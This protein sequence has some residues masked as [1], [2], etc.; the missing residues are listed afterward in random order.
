MVL[1]EVCEITSTM[2]V[3]LLTTKGESWRLGHIEYADDLCLLANNPR[4]ATALL[5]RL[6]VVLTKFHMEMAADKTKFMCVNVDD[7]P[8]EILVRAKRIEKVES[9]RYLGSLI[10][11]YGNQLEPISENI[12]KGRRQV[13]RLRPVL[14]S[15]ALN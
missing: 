3:S 8:A 2:G 12:V 10:N 11:V 14:R 7:A 13:M 15:K 4:E 5:E 9:Y 6:D 1:D